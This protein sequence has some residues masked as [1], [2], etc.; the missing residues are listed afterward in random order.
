MRTCL[1]Q[2]KDKQKA[3]FCAASRRVARNSQWGGYFVGLGAEPPALKILHFFA[4]TTSFWDYF[5]N[6]IMLLKRGIKIS[7]ANMIKLMA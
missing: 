6:K 1:H 7:C 5:E 3:S 2:L 4:K